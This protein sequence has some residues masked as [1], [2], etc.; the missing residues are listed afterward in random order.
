M[1]EKQKYWEAIGGSACPD[2]I[3]RDLSIKEISKYLSPNIDILDLG[4]GNGFCTY[5]FSK[6]E[7]RSILGVDFSSTSILAAQQELDRRGSESKKLISFEQGN[8][9][10]LSKYKNS[11]DVI[12]SVRCLINVGDMVYV[13]AFAKFIKL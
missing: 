13:K 7:P 12:I 1:T 6:T 4:C 8:A 2:D 11:F 9:M 3:M 10:D 5:E